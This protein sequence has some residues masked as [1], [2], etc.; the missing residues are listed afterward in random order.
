MKI[1]APAIKL[2]GSLRLRGKFAL[3]GIPFALSLGIL[4]Y[5][6]VAALRVDIVSARQERLGVDYLT[7]LREVTWEV[8]Q[9]RILIQAAS[10]GDTAARPILERS[11]V[12]VDDAIRKMDSVDGRL[13]NDLGST[14]A[15]AGIKEKWA[16]LRGLRFPDQ[17]REGIAGH[18]ALVSDL[19]ALVSKVGDTSGLIL[20]P[21][22]DSYYVMD[23]AMLKLPSQE[24]ALS[25]ASVQGQAV[26][27]KKA[28]SGDEKT[29]LTISLGTLQAIRAGLGDDLRADKG[30]SNPAVKD[31]LGAFAQ[32][33]AAALDD[34]LALLDKKLLGA[35]LAARPEELAA[36]TGK[37][38]AAARSLEGEALPVLDGLL[39]LRIAN[40]MHRGEVAAG[41]AGFAIVLCSLLF[42][43]LYFSLIQTIQELVKALRE[44]DL[45]AEVHAPTRDEFEDIALA[46][47]GALAGFRTVFQHMM[48]ASGQVASGSTELSSASTQMARTT[49]EMARGAQ[50]LLDATDRIAAAMR[51]LNSSIGT[52]AENAK[53][54][55]GRTATAV[56]ASDQGVEA[57][58]SITRSMDEI[59]MTTG[60]MVKAVQVIQEIANQTNLLS[61]NAAI[62]AAKAG[63]QGKGFAVVAEE[64]RKLAERSAGAAKEIALHIERCGQAVSQG[65]MTASTT[66]QTISDLRQNIIE[67]SGLVGRIGSSSKEQAQTSLEVARQ[68]EESSA[69]AIRNAEGSKEL[70]VTVNEVNRTAEDLAL[71]A[72]VLTQDLHAFKV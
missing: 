8:A 69:E 66:V 64:V 1:L 46:A 43:A 44:R 33:D 62:E 7:A 48:A 55:H 10:S 26:I 72:E 63:N 68:V 9:R 57:G 37:A 6:M 3:I 45:T 19:L 24:D 47:N 61:L 71:I 40:R 38:M 12:Q 25:L 34:V 67:V 11:A 28:I 23:A 27:G 53:Q 60:E 5:L 15:W 70:A 22:L 18:G 51:L 50:G 4:T 41:I 20:D 65:A 32:A 21:D 13:G 36:A 35:T 59:R 30:F 16:G 31:K 58:H 42:M 54:A 2:M 29:Q 49:E 39:S 56:A 52:V 14:K 17:A